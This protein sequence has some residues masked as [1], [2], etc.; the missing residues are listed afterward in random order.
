VSAPSQHAAKKADIVGGR[1]SWISPTSCGQTRPSAEPSARPAQWAAPR[2]RIA[3][4]TPTRPPRV[5]KI[6]SGQQDLNLRP[7]V[8]KTSALPGC[9]IPRFFA[10]VA[11]MRGECGQGRPRVCTATCAPVPPLSNGRQVASAT[12]RLLPGVA[13]PS[14]ATPCQ[15]PIGCDRGFRARAKNFGDDLLHRYR[16]VAIPSAV[17]THSWNLIFDPLKAAGFYSLEFQEP[18]AL[19]TRLHPP[20]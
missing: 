19:D 4:G 14:N 8:P 15:T 20:A 11:I 17:S 18:F 1:S 13:A 16:F 6:W 2:P 7:E 9:A 3:G 5:A 12:A 10:R